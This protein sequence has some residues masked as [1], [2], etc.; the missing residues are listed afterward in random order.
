MIRSAAAV[1]ALA[2]CVGQAQA[3]KLDSKITVVNRSSW[4][5]HQMFFSPV[6]ERD[7]GADQLGDKII[8]ADGGRFTL[9]GIPCDSYDIRLVDEDADECVVEGVA[10]CGDSDKWIIDDDDLLECQAETE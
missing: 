9:H 2:L 3:G 1:V 8:E 5:I 4:E 7:W 6:D 10:I